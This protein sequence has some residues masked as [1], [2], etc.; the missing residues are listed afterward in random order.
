[1]LMA[2]VAFHLL[3]LAVF[4]LIPE[5]EVQNVPV[6]VMNLQLNPG[7]GV[8]AAPRFSSDV[9]RQ[10]E[11]SQ[12]VMN[13]PAIIEKVLE[14]KVELAPKPEVKQAPHA[15]KKVEEKSQQGV[16]ITKK[17]QV[18]TPKKVAPIQAKNV[19]EKRVKVDEVIKKKPT[20]APLSPTSTPRQNVRENVVR[21]TQ[22]NSVVA[23]S[24]QAK[25]QEEIIRRY[26]Q[27]LSEWLARHK[28]YP[29]QARGQ[30][31]EGEGMVRLR[32]NRL[33][34]V[35]YA[36][37]EKSTGARILDE[38]LIAMVKRANPVPPVPNNYP[39][40]QLFEFLIP[41]RFFKVN[42]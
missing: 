2:A 10:I 40:G 16:T 3:A 9:L 38:A 37:V 31:L 28:S 11:S 32:I 7:E 26:E 14:P 39:A 21:Q 33:G 13:E 4:S 20:R 41:I 30:G 1:M 29:E 19:Q 36:A 15:P 25:V 17:K 23:S 34:N 42:E 35:I 8:T 6:R 5:Q 12:Q 27:A 18:N 22:G 24:R